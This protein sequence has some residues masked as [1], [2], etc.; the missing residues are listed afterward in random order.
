MSLD[1]LSNVNFTLSLHHHTIMNASCVVRLIIFSNCVYIVSFTVWYKGCGLSPAACSRAHRGVNIG[2]IYALADVFS[3]IFL[4]CRKTDF[5]DDDDLVAV[6]HFE[7]AAGG[8]LLR[9][10]PSRYNIT[11]FALPH[12]WR[13]EPCCVQPPCLPSII[14]VYGDQRWRWA[15]YLKIMNMRRCRCLISVAERGR[16]CFSFLKVVFNN[17]HLR[18]E[19]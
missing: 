14:H 2:R 18:S 17:N 11:S 9:D 6:V 3:H 1:L 12:F 8:A 15:K 7:P 16:I 10:L 4:C 13:E 19:P 5:K